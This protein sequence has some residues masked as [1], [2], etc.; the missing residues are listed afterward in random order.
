MDRQFKEFWESA[1][2]N[3]GKPLARIK[4]HSVGMFTL[5]QEKTGGYPILIFK[6]TGVKDPTKTGSDNIWGGDLSKGT[7][8]D[9]NKGIRVPWRW[10]IKADGSIT[11]RARE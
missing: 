3:K 10:T 11:G 5:D 2:N 8:G 9:L 1:E 7:K 6:W 4:A